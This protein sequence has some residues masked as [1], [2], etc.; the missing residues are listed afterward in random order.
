MKKKL[1]YYLSLPWTFRFEWDTRD[2]LYVASIAELKG[3]LSHGDTVEE[4]A[5]NIREA[6]E[7]HLT[8]MLNDGEA[9]PEP[10]K[11][12]AFSGRFNLRIKP[13]KHYQ[14]AKRAKIEGKSLNSLINDLLDKEA[15]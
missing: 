1:E 12:G 3:C 7:C 15:A 5:H 6:L 2:D 11:P 4:A 14:L 13:E 9:I 8:S 10:L